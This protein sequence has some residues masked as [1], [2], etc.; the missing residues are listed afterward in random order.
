MSIIVTDSERNHLKVEWIHFHLWFQRFQP[1]GSLLILGVCDWN[2]RKVLLGLLL[3]ILKW[4][5]GWVRK[6]WRGQVDSI[7]FPGCD[8]KDLFPPTNPQ[9][10]I[11][12]SNWE[13]SRALILTRSEPWRSNHFGFLFVFD[14]G[15]HY[16]TEYMTRLVKHLPNVYEAPDLIFPIPQ[17]KK[18]KIHM[19][20]CL[21]IICPNLNVSSHH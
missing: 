11:M 15:S 18:E 9:L 6:A 17:K 8:P 7:V 12:S 16:V 19:H 2:G 1:I 14:T 5:G 20:V 4:A 13:S 10:P 21:H 3:S